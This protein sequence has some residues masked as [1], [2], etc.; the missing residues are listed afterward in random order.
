MSA[1]LTWSVAYFITHVQRIVVSFLLYVGELLDHEVD[2][3]I[4]VDKKTARWYEAG[5]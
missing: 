1:T 3:V 5:L 4:V 2:T